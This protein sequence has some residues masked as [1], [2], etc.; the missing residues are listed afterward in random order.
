MREIDIAVIGAGPA[1][2]AAATVAAKSGLQTVI[3]DEQATPG[4]QIYR[5]VNAGG[6]ERGDILGPDY[7]D[8]ARLVDDLMRSGAERIDRATVWNVEADGTVTWSRNGQARQVRAQS[9]II[10]TGTV[11]RVMPVPGWTL[12]GV[13]TVGAGQILLKQSGVVPRRAVIVGCGPLI[14]LYAQQLIRS[15]AS[16]LA[17]VETQD[18]SAMRK[19]IG[20]VG[21]AVRGWRY[22]A[23]GM[24]MLRDIRSAGVSRYRGCRSVHIKG[25]ARAE[26]ISFYAGGQNVD[27]PCDTVLLHQGVIPNTQ[28]TR[29]LRAEHVWDEQ[30]QCFRPALDE[31]GR[32]SLPGIYGAGDAAGIGGAKA[33]TLRGA[34]TAWHAARSFDA[35]SEADMAARIAQIDATLAAELA[36]RPLLD[37]LYPPAAEALGPGD[38]VI[39][40]R[41]EEVTAGTIRRLAREGCIGP[42][43]M[44]A[45]TRCGMGP[46]QGRYCGPVVTNLLADVHNSSPAEIGSYHIRA[47]LKLI[48]LGELASLH[49][50]PRSRPD[51]V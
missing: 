3:L 19:A 11:E 51:V 5:A 29:S 31:W 41:C 13:M 34:R 33:A 46:C 22:I 28:I 39:V 21:G 36:V 24:T 48:T 6:R 32:T 4:G 8:G 7:L 40:C 9:I 44:K 47:P 26:G 43:Q 45:F 1:G 37:A 20:H 35:V 23:K 12:P 2:I 50:E 10:A 49:E 14:Y 15:G 25:D 17:L 38:D 27:I 16:P 42:N 18:A 30:Q